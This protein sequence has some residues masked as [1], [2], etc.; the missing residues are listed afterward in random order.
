[1]GRIILDHVSKRYGAVPA[2]D[3]VDLKIAQGEFIS[4]L[5]PSGCGKTTTLRLIA[6]LELPDDG[7]ILID[8]IEVSRPG[9]A[10]SPDKRN[11]GMVFQNYAL[12]PHMTVGENVGYPLKLRRL[13]RAESAARIRRTLALVGMAGTQDRASEQLSGGQQQRV[14]LARALIVEPTALLLDEPLSN[15]DAKLRERMRFEILELHRALRLTIVYVTH[16][17]TE[18]MSMSDRIVLMH[19][20]RVVQTGT[21]REL[22]RAPV[23]SFVAEFIGTANLVPCRVIGT[24]GRD[25]QVRLDLGASPAVEQSC[26]LADSAGVRIGEAGFFFARPENIAIVKPQDGAPITGNV[27]PVTFLGDLLDVRVSSGTFQW[28]I[29]ADPDSSVAEGDAVCLAV[30]EALFVR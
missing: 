16:D 14:A 27:G 10:L 15:L 21:A 8:E 19:D 12:W 22:Y 7:R 2:L 20:H 29:K 13:P 11:L 1:M 30:R 26:R 5:G 23:D 18:A 3:G 6:G 4:L 17:Q 9:M 28:R 24:N 25:V